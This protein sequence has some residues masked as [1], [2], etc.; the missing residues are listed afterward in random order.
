M[1]VQAFKRDEEMNGNLSLRSAKRRRDTVQ[2]SIGMPELTAA[3]AAKVK[4]VQ[5]P[6]VV[7]DRVMIKGNKRTPE[8]FVGREAV[9]TTQCLNGWYLVRTLDTGES[10]RLQ[11]RSLQKVGGPTPSNDSEYRPS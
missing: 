3:D 9:I 6:F 11:Y 4:G 7:S 2:E 8:R 10:V 5:F 1:V